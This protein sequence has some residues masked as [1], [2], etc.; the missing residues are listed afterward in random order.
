MAQRISG[1]DRKPRDLYETS[2][3]VSQALLPHVPTGNV[4]WEPAC[5]SGKMATVIKADYATDLVTTFGTSGVDFL[6]TRLD[7]VPYTTAIITNPPFNRA[8]ERFIRH[9]LD[10]M[11]PVRGFVAMLLPVDFDSA[12]TRRDI[13]GNCP[14][15]YKKLVLTSRIVWFEKDD[16]TDN[17][18]ANHAWFIWDNARH[19]PS[20]RSYLYA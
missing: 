4:I 10:L 7:V 19:T 15:F 11:S 3:W 5:A 8:A 9:S 20:P 13:F 1:Y 17:P 18:S 16:G 12:K 6:A 2:E 14:A